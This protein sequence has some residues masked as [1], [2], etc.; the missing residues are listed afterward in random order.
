MPKE[1]IIL[2]NLETGET[3]TVLEDNFC[4]PIEQ[5]TNG[6]SGFII[7]NDL[8]VEEWVIAYKKLLKDRR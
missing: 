5:F 7:A 8:K 2:I 1:E 4:Y 6:K 3:F